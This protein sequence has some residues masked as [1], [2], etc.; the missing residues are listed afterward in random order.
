MT[1]WDELKMKDQAALQLLCSAVSEEIY[2]N[3][4]SVTKASKDA[5][6]VLKLRF[7]GDSK[8]QVPHKDNQQEGLFTAT[9]GQETSDEDTWLVDSGTTSHI[10]RDEIWFTQLDKRTS[11]EV[12]LG[13]GDFLQT[14]GK[15]IVTVMTETG[16]MTI[17]DVLL[18]PNLKQNYLSIPQLMENGYVIMF[19]GSGC[20]ITNQEGKEITKAPMTDG[21]YSIKFQSM[22]NKEK[23]GETSQKKG[24]TR[25]GSHE[26]EGGIVES[27][28]MLE[29][30]EEQ[31]LTCKIEQVMNSKMNG[32]AKKGE[33]SNSQQGKLQGLMMDCLEPEL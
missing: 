31:P 28:D 29:N 19:N 16:K 2:S 10:A 9:H 18:V 26:E 3:Y 25:P 23:Q 6:D 5:W 13:G 30:K 4:L 11:T 33:S 21:S 14:K 32:N 20:T 24:V 1:F 12:R 17:R 22:R 27:A 7:Q 15:G 8:G